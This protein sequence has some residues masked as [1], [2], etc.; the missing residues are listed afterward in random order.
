[1]LEKQHIG[2]IVDNKDPLNYQRVRVSIPNITEGIDA[3]HLPW[4]PILHESM[5]K[6]SIPSLGSWVYVRFPNKDIYNG[7]IEG[8]LSASPLR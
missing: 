1:V 5:N 6:T 3:E 4:Y 8:F 7:L 2:Q